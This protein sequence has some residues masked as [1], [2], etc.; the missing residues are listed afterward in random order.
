MP[1][2]NLTTRA[3]SPAHRPAVAPSVSTA[4]TTA[5]IATVP[6]PAT[7]E[8]HLWM[9]PVRNRPG[10][11]RLLDATE[12]DRLGRLSVEEARNVFVNS[13]GAQRVIGAHY[14]GLPPEE[15][16]I[17]RDCEHCGESHGRPRFA[18]A[19]IDYSVSHTGR[20]VLTA[21]VGTGRV[22]VD[23]ESFDS[24]PEPEQV[25]PVVLTSGERDRFTALRPEERE[26]WFFR[27]WTRKEA[28]MK[29][30]GLGLTA[31]P[32]QLDVLGPVLV[33]ADVERWPAAPV[34]LRTITAPSGYAAALA[35]TVPVSSTREFPLF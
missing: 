19:P 14:L 18:H 24:C 33:V 28:A 25:A 4:V 12:Q 5:A 11:L 6:A 30:T 22:G 20:W 26:A 10:W 23:I 9:T 7:G 2:L 17:E 32:N 34:H 8:C 16:A 35:T 31:A 1:A 3:D 21:V 13:R 29:L 15:V 27:A